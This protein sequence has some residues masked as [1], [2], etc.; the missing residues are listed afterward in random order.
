[1]STIYTF[2]SMS[3]F[4]MSEIYVIRSG[5]AIGLMSETYVIGTI[6]DPTIR[7]FI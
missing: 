5:Y 1:M 7:S 6:S 2:G 3:E 4:V